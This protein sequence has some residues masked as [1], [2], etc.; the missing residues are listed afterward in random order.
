MFCKIIVCLVFVG[1]HIALAVVGSAN[2][3]AHCLLILN[4]T[5]P[6]FEPKRC[7]FLKLTVLPSQVTLLV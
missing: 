6:Q 4:L 2:S 1:K 3:L 5:C 7:V